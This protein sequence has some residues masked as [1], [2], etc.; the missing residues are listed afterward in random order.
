M[1]SGGCRARSLD[2]PDQGIP[3]Q[4]RREV[5]G[6][7]Y[8]RMGADT[9][10]QQMIPGVRKPAAKHIWSIRTHLVG[11]AENREPALPGPI[12]KPSGLTRQI[13]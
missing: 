2:L 1:P 11:S 10:I 4:R 8:R 13:P 7:L 9:R 5:P 3:R 12:P 6:Q